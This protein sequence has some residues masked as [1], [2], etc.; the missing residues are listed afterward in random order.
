MRAFIIG[1][2]LAVSSCQFPTEQHTET[3]I[4]DQPENQTELLSMEKH[5]IVFYNVENLFDIYDD[6]NNTGD[7]DFTPYGSME[8]DEERYR[9]KLHHIAEAVTMSGNELPLIIGL[10]EVENAT[11]IKDLLATGPLNK[12]N[13]GF[14]H[15]EMNDSRGMDLAFVYDKKRFEVLSSERIFVTM[16]SQPHWKARDIL[17]IQGR[18]NGDRIIHCFVNH[19]ASRREGTDKTEKR[20]VASAKILRQKVDAILAQ[21][22]RA[23]VIIMGDFNDTPV[24]NS[25]YKTLRAKGQHE[26]V[27]GDLIN[28]LI[29]EHKEGKGTITYRGDWMVFD[30]F[31]VSNALLNAKNGLKIFRNN[32]FILK[33]DRLLFKYSNGDDKPNATYGGEKYFGGYSD[34]LPIYM[35]LEIR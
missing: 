7:D 6:P 2:L 23:N 18:L 20:R 3:T 4:T 13:Y 21:D 15:I 17:Y 22:E 30:Q 19:W 28:L 24:D 12:C 31:I 1:L 9:N 32:A 16:D 34:H 29:E 11:V 33:D 14:Y 35:S 26:L 27:E 10:S 25:I 5:P 8:W